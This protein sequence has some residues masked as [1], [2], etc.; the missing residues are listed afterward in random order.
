MRSIQRLYRP[1]QTR[2]TFDF[3]QQCALAAFPQ[4]IENKL[5]DRKITQLLNSVIVKYR[6]LSVSE[7]ADQLFALAF[8]FGIG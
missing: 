5:G 6:D 8:G 7:L 2:K 4:K 3:W 1:K